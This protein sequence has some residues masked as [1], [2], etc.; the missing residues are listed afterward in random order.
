M[1]DICCLLGSLRKAGTRWVAVIPI[2]LFALTLR[3]DIFYDPLFKAADAG[4]LAGVK[5]ALAA[6][7]DVNA[8][9]KENHGETALILALHSRWHGGDFEGVA[10]VLVAAGADVNAKEDDGTTALMYA[11]QNDGLDVTRMLLDAGADVNASNGRGETPL[12]CAENGS[13]W[14]GDVVR[15]IKSRLPGEYGASRNREN[16]SPWKIGFVR[17]LFDNPSGTGWIWPAL[18]FLFA[19]SIIVWIC[20]RIGRIKPPGLSI[21]EFSSMLMG[22]TLNQP[23][24]A[25]WGFV[26]LGGGWF[27]VFWGLGHWYLWVL[28]AFYAL[29]FGSIAGLMTDRF[30]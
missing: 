30:W 14:N 4:D 12:S 8:M 18:V 20:I 17:V 15:L 23:S 21:R 3:A 19:T 11:A 24:R 27:L 9:D 26:V 25:F 16:G 28:M 6:G 29:L 13:I 1:K 2:L 5:E 22:S 7:A 10:K